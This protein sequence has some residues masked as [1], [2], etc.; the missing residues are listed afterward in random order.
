MSRW[1][2]GPQFVLYSI[3]FSIIPFSITMFYRQIF[4]IT[5]IP[6][7]ILTSIGIVL[8]VIGLVIYFVSYFV[9]NK[10]FDKGE[11][12]T[13]GIFRCCRHPLY[14][15]WVIFTVP[16]IIL[17]VNSWLGL[18]VPLFMYFVLL[19]LVRKEEDFLIEKFGD[20][21]RKYQSDVPAIWPLTMSR[22]L[23]RFAL[24]KKREK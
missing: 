4:R 11:L 13:T 20:E 17:I 6:Q 23:K 7:I 24:E 3:A 1:G 18:T 10:A 22:I 12:V 16:G 5:F 2:V 9:V 8:I 15:S 19:K 21:Y 14:A